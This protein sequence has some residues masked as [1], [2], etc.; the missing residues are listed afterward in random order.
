M[1]YAEYM[2]ARTLRSAE[3]SAVPVQAKGNCIYIYDVID[4]YGVNAG[5]VVRALAGIA[6][7]VIVRIASIGGDVFEGVAIYNAIAERAKTDQ[8]TVVVDSIAASIASLVAM[9]G[10]ELYMNS[11]SQLMVHMPWAMVAG[12][13]SDM[14][15][16]ADILEKVWNETMRPVYKTKMKKTDEE[17]DALAAAETWYS[18][19]E[20]IDAGISCGMWD[21]DA[22]G[23]SYMKEK[24]RAALAIA[25]KIREGLHAEVLPHAVTTQRA[26]GAVKLS[27]AVRLTNR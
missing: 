14:R 1:R 3:A 4:K 15:S 16:M 5:D 10:T 12:N 23:E 17:L 6:G 20:V 24:A 19:Q 2:H 11:G 18:A 22:D 13:A 8:V 21:G 25:A 27:T 7:D 9:A 26:S